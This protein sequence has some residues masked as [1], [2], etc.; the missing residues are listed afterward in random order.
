[1][2]E[3][4]ETLVV[5]MYVCIALVVIFLIVNGIAGMVIDRIMAGIGM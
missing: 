2:N 3:K 5:C 1:M 4:T